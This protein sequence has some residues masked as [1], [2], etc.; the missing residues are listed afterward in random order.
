MNLTQVKG[1]TWVAEGHELIPF[2]RLEDGRC[3]L[4]DT[5][6]YREKEELEQSL[7]NAGLTPAAIV[8]SHTHIDH[9]G[10][11]V[12]FQEKYGLCVAATAGEAAVVHSRLNLRAAMSFSA[13]QLKRDFSYMYLHPDLLLP[14]ADSTFRLLDVP[15]RAIHTPGHSPSHICTVTPDN[16]C[17]VGDALLSPEMYYAKLPYSMAIADD[18]DSKEKLRGLTCD[19]YIAAHRG[20]FTDI[21]AVVDANRALFLARAADICA[22]VD[23]P[24]P[25]NQLA[26][27]VYKKY[28]LFTHN[29]QRAMSFERNVRFFTDYLLDR[30]DLIL[31]AGEDGTAQFAPKGWQ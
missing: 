12:W 25:F 29:P 28:S 10:G 16:V 23:R 14:D 27:G 24:M 17:Y 11:A 3:I 20:V 21:D 26:A 4:L 5:G 6:L 31:V 22:L 15:F 7:L 9:S 2:Y 18:L 30:G 19:A 1:N 13:L 8:C